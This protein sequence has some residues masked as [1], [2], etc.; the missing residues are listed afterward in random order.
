MKSFSERSR[1]FLDSL[2][3]QVMVGDGAMGTLLYSRGMSLE[4]P[5]EFLNVSDPLLITLIHREYVEAGAGLLET[6]TFRANRPCLAA[7][8]L[9][10]KVREINQA[11]ARLAREEAGE[12]RFVAGSVGPL[13]RPKADRED[14]SKKEKKAFYR[15][16]MEALTEGGADILLLE[17]FPSLKDIELAVSVA[18]ELSLP[19]FAQMTFLEGGWTL[20]G[21][22]VEAAAR[23]LSDSG[24]AGIGANC[25]TGPK[26]MLDIARRLSISTRLPISIF[27]NSGYPQRINGRNIYLTTPEYFASRGRE[28]AEE[29]VSLIGGCCGTTP[30]HIRL[31]ARAVANI[32]PV[33][34]LHLVPGVPL[35]RKP[36]R[37]EGASS[38]LAGWGKEPVITVELDPLKGLDTRKIFAAAEVLAGKGI[39]AINLAENPLG[40][41]RM[42]NIALAREIQEKTGIEVIIHLT[43]RDRNLIGLHSDLMGAHLLGIRNILAVTGDPTSLGNEAG[44]SNV[45]DAT[46]VGLLK[47]IS[48]LNNGETLHGADLGGATSFLPGA[49]LNPNDAMLSDQFER[50]RKKIAAGARFVQTQPVFSAPVVKELLK[51]SRSLKIPLLIGILPLVSERNA[52][53]LHNEVPGIGIPDEVRL[54]MRGKSGDEGVRE[55]L[56]IARELIAGAGNARG[57]YLIPPFGRV[58]LA[59]DLIDF[60]RQRGK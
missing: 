23:R 29:G 32:K 49:A 60:I 25:G 58:E 34:P 31:L 33:R 56:A 12:N 17:T 52:E 35:T 14:F 22:A 53:F 24:I 13:P 1:R 46:S 11:G 38:F 39:A 3:R 54:R 15:E 7:K 10:K 40:R 27:P 47:L 6:N 42:G 4:L 45:F 55:G 36:K 20:E 19:V 30:D 8:G 5:F 43:G 59:L 50:L 57:F 48:A 41:I 16:Q 2:E 51:R 44:A 26:E 18:L 21:E 28:L 37:M 9:E